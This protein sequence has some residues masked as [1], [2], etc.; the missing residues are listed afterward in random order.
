MK[1]IVL[2]GEDSQKSYARLAKFIDTAKSRGWEIITDEFPNTP[3]LFG[4]E[5]LIIYRDY[6]KLT[7][8]DIK[9][10]DR[11]EGTLVIYHDSDL[12][13]TFIKLM[14]ADFKMEK[15]DLPKLLFGFL[16]SLVPKNSDKS[17]NLFHEVL[18]ST[19]PELVFFFIARHFRDLYWV[20]TDPASSG[21]PSWKAG[22]LK[23]Q[24]SKFSVSE[25]KEIINRLSEIDVN[26]KLSK[27]D[28]THEL[29]LLVM[30]QLK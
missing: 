22:K 20:M 19:P 24:A 1:I 30:K 7:K 4:T 6:R 21:F 13:L 26:V 2:H 18:K 27:G 17:L 16:E 10:F 14:P 9:N 12:P 29:D 25:L 8:N 3:S 23:S 5:R 11:F 28:L 15:F